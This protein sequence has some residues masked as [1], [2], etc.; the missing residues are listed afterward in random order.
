MGTTC[1]DWF[2]RDWCRR[3]LTNHVVV[4]TVVRCAGQADTAA[5]RLRIVSRHLVDLTQPISDG[6]VTHPGLP[7]P[8]IT[9]HLRF[10]DAPG[11]Y[12]E[13]TEFTI[14]RIDMVANTGTYVDAPSHRFRDGNDLAAVPLERFADLDG[15]VVRTAGTGRRAVDEADLGDL[16]VLEGRAVLLH[17]GGDASFGVPAYAE[18]APFLTGAAAQALV[19]AGVVL[20]GIDAVNIDDLGD[21]SR[22]AHTVLLGAQVVVLEHLTGLAVLPDS[23][24][25]LHAAPPA[26]HGMGTFP[27]RAYA[28]V[29]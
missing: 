12:A 14:Q 27:V 29:E 3:V 4:T 19:D 15:V 16:D 28:V 21:L 6:L 7:A 11:R 26:V 20:V 23:G 2:W 8:Q 9:D 18:D 5:T 24:F 25:R 10:E 17:T 13:G 1:I 22:P